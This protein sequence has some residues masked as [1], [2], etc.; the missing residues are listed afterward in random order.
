M[1]RWLLSLLMASALAGAV[2]R[3]DSDTCDHKPHAPPPEAFSAC[4][5]LSEGATCTAHIH[6]H[7]VAGTCTLGHET[8]LFCRPSGPPPPPPQ[9]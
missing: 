1:T 3:A 8:Q 2:A 5:D 6:D 7:D 4:R 9:P